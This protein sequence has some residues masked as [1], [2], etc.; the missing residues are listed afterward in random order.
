[1]LAIVF[2]QLGAAPQIVFKCR[3][4]FYKRFCPVTQLRFIQIPALHGDQVTF[5]NLFTGRNFHKDKIR[6]R[7]LT[8]IQCSVRLACL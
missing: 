8:M 5:H 6:A 2:L 3:L 1:M 7:P 4:Q